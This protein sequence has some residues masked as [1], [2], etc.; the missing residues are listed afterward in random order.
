MIYASTAQSLNGLARD[1]LARGTLNQKSVIRVVPALVS[2]LRVVAGL[3]RLFGKQLLL[4]HFCQEYLRM[5]IIFTRT[6]G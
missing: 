1:L 5:H 6:A 4:N 3:Q 2:S